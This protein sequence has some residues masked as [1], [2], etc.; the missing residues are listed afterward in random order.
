[1]EQEVHE[2][3]GEDITVSYDVKR[4][5][6]ARECVRGLPAVFD[7]DEHP[8]IDPDEADADDLAEVITLCPTGA[9]HFERKDGGREE[10]TPDENVIEVVADGPLYARG[11][12]EIVDEDGETLLTDTRVA[13]CRC[14]ASGNKPLCDNSHLGIEFE[15]PGLVLGEM[16][17]IA[18]SGQVNL[19][20]GSGLTMDAEVM[21][22]IEPVLS[23]ALWS[24][25]VLGLASLGLNMQEAALR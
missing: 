18:A 7:P 3:D 14:G 11:D 22:A 19:L 5:I 21:A 10:T 15:A 16:A 1:M 17:Q 9:L 12:V 6:H 25:A 13:F 4:C 2:Y 24:E 8:W 20:D 23:G